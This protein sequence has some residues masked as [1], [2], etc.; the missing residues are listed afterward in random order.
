MGRAGIPSQA[1]C[2]QKTPHSG[3]SNSLSPLPVWFHQSPALTHR[4]RLF[5]SYSCALFWLTA[6]ALLQAA[7]IS[8]LSTS[9]SNY[10]LLESNVQSVSFRSK[11]LRTRVQQINIH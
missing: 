4:W 10:Q 2:L 3:S 5:D 1:V 7:G 6:I 9:P 8:C 11:V